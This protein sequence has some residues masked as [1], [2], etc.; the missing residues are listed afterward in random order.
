MKPQETADN[1]FAEGQAA[2]EEKKRSAQGFWKRYFSFYDTLNEALPYRRM[3][4]R[5]AELLAPRRGELV[6]DAGTGTGNVAVELLKSGAH[7][8]GIDF[9]E[10]ALEMCRV[11]APQG[12]FRFGDL[13][14]PLEFADDHFDKIACCCVLHVLNR[15][16]QEF[17]VKEFFRVVKPGGT[18]AVTAFAKGFNPNKVYL[19]TLRQKRQTS[20]LL[21]AL[22]FTF[23]HSVNT[24][25]IL[26][27]VWR[28]R[29]REQSGE[30]DFLSPEELKQ[31]LE[32]A[33]F[34]VVTTERIFASQCATALARKPASASS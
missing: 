14:Q 33:G 4:E 13:T 26:Y 12:E 23:R 22:L 34:E 15:D 30:Y 9:V 11:K 24:A 21:D 25:R 28:I 19:E 7:V 5:H 2:S 6:L 20:G 1:L 18:V 32:S 8:V 31:M 17:A 10:S 29:R 27:Y 16:A 3:I